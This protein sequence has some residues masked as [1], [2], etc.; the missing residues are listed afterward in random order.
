[1]KHDVNQHPEDKTERV[2]ED[3]EALIAHARERHAALFAEHPIAVTVLMTDFLMP[4]LREL[5]R[6]FDGDVVKAIVLG[7]IGQA[8]MRR[9]VA[10]Q[11]RDALPLELVDL[12]LRHSLVRGCNGL[13]VSMASGIAKE[14]VRRKIKDLEAEG[15]I[16]NHP[17]GGWQATPHAADRF[18]PTFNMELS[19]RLLETAL[20][21]ARLASS[22]GTSPI[23]DL[24][25]RASSSRRDDD[26]DKGSD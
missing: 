12:E 11:H 17:E 21:I 10:S 3:L 19:R 1:M 20:R 24:I 18:S 15:L 23:G 26:A 7:E 8:N 13:S 16:A 14:T 6:A 22:T 25:E 9:F 4:Y 2:D 5:Y